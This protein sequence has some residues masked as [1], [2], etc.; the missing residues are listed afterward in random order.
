M[1]PSNVNLWFNVTDV[2]ERAGDGDT[3]DGDTGDGDTG[4]SDVRSAPDTIAPGG[5]ATVTLEA[6]ASSSSVTLQESFSPAFE[7]VT[8]DSVT[9]NGNSASPV[10]EVSESTGIVV[11]LEGLSQD[12]TVRV[13]YTVSV[14]AN[15][16]T[17]TNYT[18]VGNV[19]SDTTTEFADDQITVQQGSPLSDT[20]GRYDGDFDGQITIRELGA[21]AADYAQGNIDI[22]ALG[23][24]AAT[25]AQS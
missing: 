25:Y 13:E 16:Q 11:T 24:V 6:N 9:V 15:A 19:T 5:S 2:V 20:P 21:A 4:V 10:L 3:G 8:I 18:L 23:Q 12:D 14:S 17:G 7:N 1:F 22:R